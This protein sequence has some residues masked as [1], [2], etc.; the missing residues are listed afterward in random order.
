MG[1]VASQLRGQLPLAF[2]EGKA[3]SFELYFPGPNRE[4]LACV[5]APLDGPSYLYLWGASGTGKTHLLQ[6]ACRHV[7][8]DGERRC[9]YLPLRHL[10]QLDVEILEGLEAMDLVCVDDLHYA[11]AR[12]AW[13]RG[14]FHFF[15]RLRES[16]A[17]LIIA[18]NSTPAELK[19]ELADLSSRL[20]GGLVVQLKAL[21]DDEK[22]QALQRRAIARGLDLPPE[23]A[24]Y[25]LARLPRD[26]VALCG[27]LE[28]L[29]ATSLA[30]QRRLTVPLV[31]ALIRSTEHQSSE[32]T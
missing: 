9:A 3:P 4:A 19:I 11:A 25:L 5:T 2:A 32:E 30:L 10:E 14:L 16:D 21:N 7:A 28:I 18:G 20:A 17:A 12:P 24:H 6:A 29:D 22:L 27:F 13:E 23:V 1:T 26:M 15:N 31:R 8:E